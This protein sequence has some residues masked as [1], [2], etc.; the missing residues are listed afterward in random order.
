MRHLYNCF[1]ECVD[2]VKRRLEP[3]VEGTDDGKN[4]ISA[5]F[6]KESDDNDGNGFSK[7]N[8]E[9]NGKYTIEFELSKGTIIS[10]Y[11]AASGRFTAPVGTP[12]EC[13][14]LPFDVRTVEYHEYEVIADGVRVRLFVV[15]GVSAPAFNSAGGGI[16]YMHSCSISDEIRR[17]KLKEVTSWLKEK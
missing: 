5:E 3:G 9:A 1:G 10:R 8:E 13:R 16:Q 12:Y 4:G 15:K 2:N 7:H 14:G 17:G 6:P 11:G